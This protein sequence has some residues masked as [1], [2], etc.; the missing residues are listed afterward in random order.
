MKWIPASEEELARRVPA[1]KE[2]A[3]AEGGGTGPA[4]SEGAAPAKKA[5]AKKKKKA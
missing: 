3:K 5:P 2:P 1:P 4:K